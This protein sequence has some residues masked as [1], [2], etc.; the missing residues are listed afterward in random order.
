[1]RERFGLTDVVMV[2][3]RGMITTARINA[4]KQVGGLGWVTS[5]RAPAIRALVEGG[6]LQLSLFDQANLAEISHPDYPGE[7]LV[8]CR[9][10]ALAAE[11]SRKRGELLAATQALLAPIAATVNAG[12]LV[13]ADKI[14]IRVGKVVNRH[15]MAKHFTLTITDT[16]FA[17]TPNT[18]AIDAEAALD[19]IYVIRAS[20]AHTAALPS[21]AVIE[22]YKNLAYVEANFRS[23]K[24]IDLDLRPI[25]HWTEQR[26][27]THV[28][29]CMLASYIVWH[30]RRAWA[31]LCFTDETKP[32]PRRPRRPS[33]TLTSRP[34]QS[35]PPTQQQ[36]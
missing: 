9:N 10:P 34:R 20:A 29:I 26:V 36:R 6:T 13:G 15:K 23:L 27:R 33:P 28:F 2:G 35:I 12:K 1:M 3:D 8:A 16:S 18:E 30:L 5:L 31:P 4:L 22:A 21:P 17:Y 25:H 32:S 11:R 19:G 24:A 7:R 14:G